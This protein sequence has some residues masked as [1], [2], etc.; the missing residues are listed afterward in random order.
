MYEKQ[1]LIAL[2]VMVCNFDSFSREG[3]LLA[4]PV[5]IAP[6]NAPSVWAS[7][8]EG[9]RKG[10]ESSHNESVLDERRRK[11]LEAKL[12]AQAAAEAAQER[13]LRDKSAEQAKHN[14]LLRTLLQGYHPSKNSEYVLKILQSSLPLDI[15]QCTIAILNQQTD[16]FYRDAVAVGNE[17][18]K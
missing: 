13:L 2:V 7:F 12:A 5:V 15:K 10:L 16:R 3:S 1:A 11:D 17:T 18:E 8:G 4:A 6:P 14:N 9:L